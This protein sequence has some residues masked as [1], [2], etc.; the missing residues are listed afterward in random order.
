MFTSTAERLRVEFSCSRL[1]CCACWEWAATAGGQM[2]RGAPSRA[3]SRGLGDGHTSVATK[4]TPGAPVAL[5]TDGRG[6]SYGEC[7]WQ[8]GWCRYRLF[9]SGAG[10]LR[11]SGRA[12]CRHLFQVAGGR[13]L[14]LC[15]EK[16]NGREPKVHVSGSGRP[17]EACGLPL[18]VAVGRRA[19]AQKQ[20][21]LR[22]RRTLRRWLAGA[23]ASHTHMR[24]C[25]QAGLWVQAD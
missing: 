11:R 18:P 4:G 15:A 3:C 1:P 7:V 21:Q 17:V 19:R 22:L 10:S 16:T 24:E 9:E 2:G 23:R 13:H 25:L 20:E 5:H 14:R 12:P 8:S 6:T